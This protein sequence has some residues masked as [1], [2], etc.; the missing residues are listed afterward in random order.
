[1]SSRKG[2]FRAPD[3]VFDLRAR[4]TPRS[5]RE[6]LKNVG[7]RASRVLVN[8]GGVAYG[9]ESR[10]VSLDWTLLNFLFLRGTALFKAGI[11]KG[12]PRGVR[13]VKI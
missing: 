12:I 10:I 2:V 3:G 5:K 11:H 1:M 7:V 8:K 6:S 13:M 4:D 9:D